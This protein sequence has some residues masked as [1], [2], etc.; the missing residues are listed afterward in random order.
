[1]TKPSLTG[2]Y[3]YRADKRWR[4]PPTLVLQVEEQISYPVPSPKG[5]SGYTYWR[6]ARVEDVINSKSPTL[7]VLCRDDQPHEACPPP[8]KDW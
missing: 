6:D 1:M 8:P 5:A 2:H 4:R 7:V 3:R